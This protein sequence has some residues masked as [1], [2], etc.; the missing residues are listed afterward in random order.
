MVALLPHVD[1][2][3]VPANPSDPVL[4]STS[5]SQLRSQILI[6]GWLSPALDEDEECYLADAERY[7][8]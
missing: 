1:N 8:G 7:L 4:K 5:R 6:P 3:R 2:S